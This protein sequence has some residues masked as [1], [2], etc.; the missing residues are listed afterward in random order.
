VIGIACRF[1][2]AADREAFWR[3]LVDGV[4]SITEVP[5]AR[6]DWR[7]HFAV[8]RG[9]GRIVSRWGGFLDGHDL[10]DPE[11]FR[12]T[13]GEARAMSPQQRL[14]L[15]TAWHALEDAG[16]GRTELGGTKCGVFVG[17]APDGWGGERADARSSL[18]DS[19]A[20]L[21]ARLAYA[22]DL[23]GACLP[24]DT[25]CSSSLVAVHMA[26]RSLLS[27]DTTMALAGGVSVLMGGPRLHAFLSD[28]GM[29]SPTGLCR[30]F[31]AGA[32]GFVPG[33][34]VGVV[35]LKRLDRARAEGDQ[36]YAVIKASGVNQDGTTSGIT[37]PSGAAQTAL[38]R[39]VY[40]RGGIDARRIG[41]VEAHGTGTQLGDPIE[42]KALV[43]A[44]RADTEAVGFCRIGS[45]KSNI[46]HTLTAAGIAGFIKAALAVGRGLVPPS[47]H[48][49]AANPEIDFAASPF[50]VPTTAERW[51]ETAGHEEAGYPRLA[52]VSSFGF[53]GT[54][55]HVVLAEP[56]PRRAPAPRPGLR[57]V[58]VSAKTAEAL[59]RRLADL[60]DC[61]AAAREPFPWLAWT[62]TV[63]R[64][65]FEHRAAILAGDG[66]AF[67]E[68]ARALA[69]NRASPL[70]RRVVVSARQET[71][72][73]PVV[74][75]T[76]AM[77]AEAF[78]AGRPADLAAVFDPADRIRIS[79]P[80]YP[81][82]RLR[83][84]GVTPGL[85]DAVRSGRHPFVGSAE[86]SPEGRRFPLI[87]ADRWPGLADHRHVGRAIWPAAAL[88]EAIWAVGRSIGAW[89]EGFA[90]EDLAFVAPLALGDPA[91]LVAE[92]AP[93]GGGLSLRLSGAG[94]RLHAS[95]RLRSAVPTPRR[96]IDLAALG[97]SAGRRMDA[98]AAYGALA[99]VGFD[100][101][102]AFRMLRG[103]TVHQ[104]RVLAELAPDDAAGFDWPPGRTDAAIQAAVGLVLTEVEPRRM[105]VLPAGVAAVRLHD[106]LAQ[107]TQAL[108]ERRVAEP[109]RVQLDI[110]LLDPDGRLL[111]ELVGFQAAIRPEAAETADAV[112]AYEPVWLPAGPP[113]GVMPAD[114]DGFAVLCRDG[115]PPP[116]AG[117]RQI[118][119][120]CADAAAWQARFGALAA[121]GMLPDRIADLRPLAGPSSAGADASA[122]E[123]AIQSV[124]AMLSGWLLAVPGRP[125]RLIRAY[126]TEGETVPA[127]AALEGLAA[128]LAQEAPELSVSLLGLDAAAAAAP[129]AALASAF[130][131]P[132]CPHT[133]VLRDALTVRG[134]RLMPPATPP[135]V[136]WP[137][138]PVVIV[139]GAQGGL[140]QASAEHLARTRQ[141]RLVLLSR[142]SAA[143]NGPH[144]RSDLARRIARLGGEAV[145]VTADVATPAGARHAVEAALTAF[146]RVDGVIHAAGVTRDG[147]LRGRSSATA[148]SRPSSAMP[149]RVI[150]VRPMPS[151]APWPS[152]AACR[153]LRSTGRSGVTAASRP[154]TVTTRGSAKPPARA[155]SKRRKV[156]PC[157]IWRS[158]PAG[159]VWRWP[160]AARG[161]LR[162]SL[163]ARPRPRPSRRRPMRRPTA[164]PSCAI[165]LPRSPVRR[166][167][168]CRR[169]GRSRRSPSIPCM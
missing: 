110:S 145:D 13:H 6:W 165:C 154:V 92:P 80:L 32:D 30:S 39:E 83:F 101:G 90:L 102:P 34:G 118:L 124:I 140:G 131:R 52:A 129:M 146:G 119:Q 158:S 72:G 23:K 147:M 87:G 106:P 128:A 5:A 122:A 121:A 75:E 153:S 25:A 151:S 36:I 38:E 67:S 78:L 45:V 65:H 17:V 26:A 48:Y 59:D 100:Y 81:F 2:G 160:P 117:A 57:L 63:G 74:P 156:L 7:P 123:A 53:S 136:T 169:S 50:R 93:E 16:Y 95:G 86:E 66:G 135:A 96:R 125:L 126:R 143:V 40:A 4:C 148:R 20:I 91:W 73:G 76:P 10:F 24:I 60:A 89:G 69:E 68:A 15:E 159:P 94:G 11:P 61:A 138:R 70:G 84:P 64:T 139:T 104:D 116:G 8:G 161:A 28:S 115:E 108:V 166:G 113:F 35:V 112:L 149:G 157:S 137:D 164:W 56:P 99:A 142:R 163:P 31:D 37:A 88:I 47:L 43:R 105:T 27:G 33:E 150:T 42:V 132:V 41:L 82:E 79:L 133:R 44:F 127:E 9:E 55:A 19:N 77:A 144:L 29:A 109:G 18:G 97:L 21:S 168:A 85:E 3:N 134:W 46:G 54:N 62:A 120:P 12:I 1:P 141:A 167:T 49:R 58:A 111:A 155:G 71:V 114:A 152:T 51:S 107:A 130:A 98:G 14:F 22:L 162:R 103:V